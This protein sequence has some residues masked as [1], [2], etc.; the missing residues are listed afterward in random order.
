MPKAS[1]LRSVL[2]RGGNSSSAAAIAIKDR[3]GRIPQ[4]GFQAKEGGGG[5]LRVK[6]GRG[7]GREKP[8]LRPPVQHSDSLSSD[9][10]VREDARGGGTALGDEATL[11]GEEER[12]LVPGESRGR[13]DDDGGS[14]EGEHPDDDTR[15]HGHRTGRGIGESG[16]G[17]A[18][19]TPAVDTKRQSSPLTSHLRRLNPGARSL[20]SSNSNN[21]GSSGTTSGKAATGKR[22][23]PDKGAS[24][25]PASPSYGRSGS[26]PT[27]SEE[28]RDRPAASNTGPSVV[29][30]GA[31]LWAE[32]SA[33]ISNNDHGQRK[34]SILHGLRG[35]RRRGLEQ[36]KPRKT[37]GAAPP[38]PGDS[39][40]AGSS[41][42]STPRPGHQ[43]MLPWRRGGGWD[44][45]DDGGNHEGMLVSGKGR[46]AV[47]AVENFLYGWFGG[48]VARPWPGVGLALLPDCDL[49]VRT[50]LGVGVCVP[51]YFSAWTIVLLFGL[52]SGR[53]ELDLMVSY[54]SRRV[55]SIVRRSGT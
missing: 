50:R 10:G 6:R 55:N 34:R 18:A 27:T 35:M 54:L 16:D 51:N 9:E 39:T 33:P 1:A 29:E 41:R 26:S 47:G 14:D 31:P 15:T 3:L 19:S 38:S 25:S 52:G 45:L 23:R 42:R 13:E 37:E 36:R 44:K 4:F 43:R 12:S 30:M 46:P 7:L 2:A 40:S 49:E 21:T 5:A 20:R 32:S 22:R 24:S 28:E 53:S 48:L 11:D 8:G 17:V